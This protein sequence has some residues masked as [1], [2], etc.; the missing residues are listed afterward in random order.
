MGDIGCLGT[1][2]N[3]QDAYHVFIGGGFG[4]HQ[5]IGRQ[6]F[7]GIIATELPKTVEKLLAVYLNHRQGAE[8]F[9][10]FSMR[11]EIGRLQE[12]FAET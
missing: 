3:G 4:K 1:K 12:L 6:I 2:A 7:A 9:K 5:S 11:H 10:E 8:S